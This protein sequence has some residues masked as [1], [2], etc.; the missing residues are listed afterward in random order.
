MPF[1]EKY[2][3]LR[4]SPDSS[5]NRELLGEG[6]KDTWCEWRNFAEHDKWTRTPEFE[7]PYVVLSLTTTFLF[8][9]SLPGSIRGDV[10]EN[11]GKDLQLFVC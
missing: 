6:A 1:F 5:L 8:S 7:I 3:V 11:S 4:L 10:R 9:L 2:V